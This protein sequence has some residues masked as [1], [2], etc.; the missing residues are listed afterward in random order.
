MAF[1]HQY[2]MAWV[3]TIQTDRLKNRLVIF[4]RDSISQR[5]VQWI[6]FAL[7]YPDILMC[8][9]RDESYDVHTTS[10]EVRLFRESILHT[11][12]S[13]QSWL[14]QWCKKLLPHH[15]RGARRCRCTI[16]GCDTC[17][18]TINISFPTSD[19]DVYRSSSRIPRTISDRRLLVEVE[20]RN[21]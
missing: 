10:H 4:V 12:G 21:K 1:L 16:L 19:S 8:V 6:I 18:I 3:I 9:Q 7:H 15:L 14:C 11:C 2:P 17:P 13:W 20:Q 5:K